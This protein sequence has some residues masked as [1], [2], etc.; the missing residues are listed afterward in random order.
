MAA[1]VAAVVCVAGGPTVGNG[2]TVLRAGVAVRV[3]G[4]ET[5]GSGVAVAR[6]GVGVAAAGPG[7]GMINTCP[8]LKKQLF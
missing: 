7:V 5:V 8:A 2:V 4:A 3:A 6:A 1:V